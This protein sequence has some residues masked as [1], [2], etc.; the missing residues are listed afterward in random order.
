MATALDPE[1]SLAFQPLSFLRRLRKTSVNGHTDRQAVV[2]S[3]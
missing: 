2:D 1:R 3:E